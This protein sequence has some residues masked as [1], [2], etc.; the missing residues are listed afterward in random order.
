VNLLQPGLEIIDNRVSYTHP[1]TAG[2]KRPAFL[3]D[4]PEGI[5]AP[6]VATNKGLRVAAVQ[7]L[8]CILGN[9]E[10]PISVLSLKGRNWLESTMVEQNEKHDGSIGKDNIPRM[11]ALISTTLS[12]ELLLDLNN[13]SA[14]ID[15]AI[16]VDNWPAP[17]EQHAHAVVV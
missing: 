13:P 2:L 12:H 1:E 5:S 3:C 4:I 7:C 15:Y 6:I 9:R 16:P 11:L 8:G 14:Q 10:C 17:V